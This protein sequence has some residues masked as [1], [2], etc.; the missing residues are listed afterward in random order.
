MEAPINII[1]TINCFIN[2]YEYDLSHKHWLVSLPRVRRAKQSGKDSDLTEIG[3][4]LAGQARSHVQQNTVLGCDKLK[5]SN[6]E[7][8]QKGS[9]LI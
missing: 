8:L 2:S 5:G 4:N 3:Y 7:Q 1:H 6:A 9:N